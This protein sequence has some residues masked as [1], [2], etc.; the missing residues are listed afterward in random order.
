MHIS[1]EALNEFIDL[2]KAEFGQ[3]IS[4]S[5]ASEVATGILTLAG[6]PRVAG[7]R[8]ALTH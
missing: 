2:Y 7:M 5:E 1:D 8:S 4:R 3:D 6:R